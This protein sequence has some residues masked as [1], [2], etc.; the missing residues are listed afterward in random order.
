MA[1]VRNKVVDRARRF[2]R[3]T[4]NEI[5]VDDWAEIGAAE[6]SASY[7][8]RYGDPEALREV[9]SRRSPLQQKAIELFKLREVTSKEAATLMGATPGALRV[10]VHRAI[11]S[12]RASLDDAR[13][14][15]CAG[16]SGHW[17]RASRT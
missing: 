5:L 2:A 12:L 1:I 17:Q 7:D 3:S 6:P 16:S 14:S 10:S 11:K 15:R 13:G 4:A 8:E 9:I